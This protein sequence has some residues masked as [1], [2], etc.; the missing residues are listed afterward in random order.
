ME[1]PD[2]TGSS[3][4]PNAPWNQPDPELVVCRYCHEEIEPEVFAE[5]E[6][7]ICPRCSEGPTDEEQWGATSLAPDTR[8]EHDPSL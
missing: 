1:H 6:E 3:A 7:D 8:G 2:H 4:N 5:T